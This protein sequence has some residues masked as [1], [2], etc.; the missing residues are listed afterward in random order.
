MEMTETTRATT[1]EI[2]MI[3]ITTCTSFLFFM[4]V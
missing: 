4:L 3:Q 2:T 1:M